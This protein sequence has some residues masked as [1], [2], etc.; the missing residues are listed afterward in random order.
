[1][2][3]SH[4]NKVK[5]PQHLK[6]RKTRVE[7]VVVVL[8]EVGRLHVYLCQIYGRQP[9]ESLQA[10]RPGDIYTII[11]CCCF[12]GIAFY[13]FVDG[14]RY[15]R[16]DDTRLRDGRGEDLVSFTGSVVVVA[17]LL[18]RLGAHTLR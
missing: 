11:W 10:L 12:I 14:P 13:I 7:V 4:I 15:V 9:L 6:T 2:A 1:M 3:T 18:P 8:L 16:R 17:F 5:A